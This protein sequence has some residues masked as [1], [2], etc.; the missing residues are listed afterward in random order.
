MIKSVLFFSAIFL[1]NV[2][3]SQTPWPSSNWDGS[4][5]LTN[6][7]SSSGVEGLSGV[8]YN[9][10]KKQLFMVQDLGRLRVIQLNEQTGNHLQ[11]TDRNLGGDP[12]GITQINDEENEFWVI[13]ENDHKIERYQYNNNF[14]SVNMIRSWNLLSPQAGM[15]ESSNGG[16]EG[17]CFIPD[18]Y[19]QNSGFLSSITGLS[20]TS[21]KGMGGLIF[22]A[23]QDQGKIWVYD[24]NQN[25]NDDLVLVGIYNTNR[26]ESC[27]LS[28][29]KSTGLLYI[30]HNLDNNYLEVSNLGV[31]LQGQ[32]YKFNMV[33]EFHVTVPTNGGKNIEGVAVSPK[34]EDQQYPTLWLVRDISGSNSV[35]ALRQF[36][37]FGL[38]GTCD[39]SLVNNGEK[40]ELPLYPNPSSGLVNIN[41]EITQNTTF[42]II[43]SQGKT[44]LRIE[45]TAGDKFLDL[46]GLSCGVYLVKVQHL[47]SR[48]IIN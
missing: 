42:E 33:Q 36:R 37:P 47:V 40:S 28:F 9:P 26:Q 14:S 3:L 45:C 12:E 43:D 24:I 35:H 29:D 22:I 6:I 21:Q 46:T 15:S 19:L 44:M 11:L 2:A 39:A 10:T 5:N 31:I 30:L 41:F 17:I 38:L 8:H 4:T 23:H 7:M 34:C 16:P 25:V 48:L 20:Y 18:S 27:G 13:N 32:N 1:I